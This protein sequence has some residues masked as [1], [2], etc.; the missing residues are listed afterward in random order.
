MHNPGHL[1]SNNPNVPTCTDCHSSGHAINPA[2]SLGQDTT[3][4]C[5]TCHQEYTS[6]E[7]TA[8]HQVVMANLGAEQTCQTCHTDTWAHNPAQDC[9][10]CHRFLDTDLTL[11]SGETIPLKVDT[12]TILNSMH[13]SN[14][15]DS[16]GYTPF[17]CTDC[18]SNKETYTFPHQNILPDDKRSFVTRRSAICE[19]CHA[20]VSEKH[21]DSTHA[22]ARAEGNLDAA[23]CIDCH[24][25]HDVHKA[26]EPREAIS[27]TCGNCHTEINEE[28]EASVHG[29]AL[30][31]EQNP[32][33]PLCIDCHGVHD[34]TDP[35]TAQYR[36]DSPQ[37]CATCHADEELMSEYDLSHHVLD[38]YVA[39]FHGTTV[40][41]FEDNPET[42]PPSGRLF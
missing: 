28:Y 14:L 1:F 21:G 23:T 35:T 40:E 32:D 11:D 26:G 29:E 30:L 42:P 39:D 27:Q 37:L 38:T 18:H 22:A 24:G 19:D 20:A 10:T 31:G 33:V 15:T 7:Q 36:L 12:E 2:D 9:E 41:L 5:Q 25:A 3:A 34:I 6:P 16:Y 13:G 8:M 4:T 17:Q